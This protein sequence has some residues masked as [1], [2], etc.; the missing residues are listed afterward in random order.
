MTV[1]RKKDEVNKHKSIDEV[2]IETIYMKWQFY[3]STNKLSNIDKSTLTNASI[4]DR[5]ASDLE[6]HGFVATKSRKRDATIVTHSR[7]GT[8]F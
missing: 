6:F 7:E 3:N 1:E 5:D 8:I 2:T 4:R